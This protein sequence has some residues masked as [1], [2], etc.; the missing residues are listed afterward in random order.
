M[1]TKYPKGQALYSELFLKEK[2][3]EVISEEVETVSFIYM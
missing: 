2:N 3:F 1:N